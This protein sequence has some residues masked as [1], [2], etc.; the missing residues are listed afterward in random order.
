MGTQYGFHVNASRCTGCKTCE[1]ACRDA[2]QLGETPSFRRVCEASGGSWVEEGGAWW[3]HV[4]AYYLSVSCNH[5]DDPICQQVCPS[6]AMRKHDDGFVVLDSDRCIGCGS[7][8]FACPYKAP[9]F[10]EKLRV[11]RKCDGCRARVSKGKEPVCVEACPMRALEFGEIGGLRRRW[12]TASD[13]APLPE[14]R[15]TQPNL[16]ITPHRFAHQSG[17]G[18]AVLAN[19]KEI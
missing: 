5:C 18:A 4:F 8:A 10:S 9:S 12:G 7:C 3:H 2:Y 17:S 19:E 15:Y 16:V 14:S 13:V 6:G 11:M 1:M